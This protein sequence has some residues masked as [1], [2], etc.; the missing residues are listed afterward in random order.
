MAAADDS[1]GAHGFV[2]IRKP[3]SA[4]H[5]RPTLVDAVKTELA[6]KW[7]Q[8]TRAGGGSSPPAV[9]PAPAAAADDDGTDASDSEWH[10]V[11]EES[12]MT[13]VTDRAELVSR[14]F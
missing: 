7:K 13:D 11:G 1:G 5:E 14:M 9:A 6:E 12:D 10:D 3:A 4:G 8:V 2:F